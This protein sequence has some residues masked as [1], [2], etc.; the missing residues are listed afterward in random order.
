MNPISA[1]PA[2]GR[3]AG[4]GEPGAVPTDLA[5]VFAMLF[6]A[7]TAAP[8]P[9]PA[10]P[11]VLPAVGNAGATPA[12]DVMLDPEAAPRA[13]GEVP[14]TP[15]GGWPGVA[16]R[17]L[18]AFPAASAPGRPRLEPPGPSPTLEDLAPPRR[19]L[20][21]PLSPPLPRE[22]DAA[23]VPGSTRADAMPLPEGMTLRAPAEPAPVLVAAIAAAV[24]QVRP[25]NVAAAKPVA[26]P[27]PGTEA[28]TPDGE[29]LL[30]E[31][32]RDGGR[33]VSRRAVPARASDREA[34]NSGVRLRAKPGNGANAGAAKSG[35]GD[36][37]EAGMP[38][39]F[40]G[41][42]DPSAP[43]APAPVTLATH[44][45]A[46]GASAPHVKSPDLP[47]TGGAAAAAPVE[48]PSEPPVNANPSHA[49][50]SFDSGD[51]QEG[52]LR[53]SLR[54]DTLRATIQ[55][56]DAAAAQRLEQDLGE[57]SRA[58]RTHGFEEA[59]LTVDAPRSASNTE[60]GH[61]DTQPREHK[62]LRDERSHSGERNSARRERGTSRQER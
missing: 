13:E 23:V 3:A 7:T 32:A 52:R 28:P 2:A 20:A 5:G 26:T 51:G 42:T 36:A 47:A 50:V 10:P 58:L 27:A 40:P 59:R 16:S 14:Q 11:V 54:G 41:A 49:T 12:A 39:A 45:H 31:L 18:P 38:S 57:L 21:A 53:V 34:A 22:S 25:A 55:M 30:A 17:G 61:D 9:V 33:G 1:T 29:P 62:N 8:V 35:K 24:P 43:P 48:L 4:T 56:P 46:A 6:A 44:A 19:D 37:N 15:P 60:R